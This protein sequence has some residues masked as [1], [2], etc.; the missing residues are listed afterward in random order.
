MPKVLREGYSERH[1]DYRKKLWPRAREREID[2]KREGVSFESVISGQAPF[3]GGITV[4]GFNRAYLIEHRGKLRP[5][6]V[7]SDSVH[8]REARPVVS[9]SPRMTVYTAS[10]HKM[11]ISSHSAK[12]P[13]R[14]LLPMK[15]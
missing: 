6:R 5:E 10:R 11:E 4:T 1:H 13:V 3:F 15:Q 8:A 2:R 12:I 9:K 7:G 14:G